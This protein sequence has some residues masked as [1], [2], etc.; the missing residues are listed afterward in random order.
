MDKAINLNQ[1]RIHPSSF[2][3]R[4]WRIATTGFCFVSFGLGG[5]FL[6]V[7]IFPL[8]RLCIRNQDYCYLL[9]QKII[10]SSFQLFI[11]MMRSFGILNI[12]FEHLERLEEDFG[13][14]IVA[15][16][17]SLIDY[18]FL[19]SKMPRCDC[20]VKETLLRNIFMKGV[21][22][23]SGY[24]P[25]SKPEVLLPA[26]QEKLN[27]NGMLLVFPEGTRTGV[28]KEIQIQ[29]GAANIA[30]RTRCDIRLISIYCDFPMLTKGG[31]WY[32][33]PPAKPTF[34]I[35]V[36]NKV[37]INKFINQEDSLSVDARRLTRYLEQ[38]LT[39]NLKKTLE[40]TYEPE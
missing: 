1:G 14:L 22:K 9:T 15:N 28:D 3:N 5:L 33:I 23:A 39:L 16:H 18:V 13:C 11:Y 35:S 4:L 27:K 19:A 20:I 2:L 31:K 8:V 25:N 38:Q 6:T 40:S 37:E 10:Q 34:I 36:N 21:I 30:L 17:P 29:R 32:N 7:F 24:I 26:C 12:R